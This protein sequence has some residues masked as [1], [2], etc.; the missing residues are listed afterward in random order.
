MIS[1]ICRFWAVAC[2]F[3]LSMAVL[4]NGFAPTGETKYWV[5][6][7]TPPFKFFFY[8]TLDM[9]I[10]PNLVSIFGGM[11]IWHPTTE[12]EVVELLAAGVQV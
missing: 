4:S 7:S 1:L 10:C 12:T 11:K 3:T 8:Y 5:K 9:A 6:E 2:L